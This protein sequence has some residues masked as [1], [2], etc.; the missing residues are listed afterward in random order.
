[1]VKAGKK[2]SAARARA[3][4]QPRL[5][6]PTREE[7]RKA[8]EEW[9]TAPEADAPLSQEAAEP[10][11]EPPADTA[12]IDRAIAHMTGASSPAETAAHPAPVVA[13]AKAELRAT[14]IKARATATA[15]RMRDDDEI[16]EGVFR[17]PFAEELARRIGEP[18]KWNYI[19]NKMAEWEIWPTAK[20]RPSKGHA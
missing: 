12:R 20:I 19:R 3:K 16:P 9:R 17:K 4:R 11:I 2:R 7:W 18:E 14:T 6:A 15:Q 13:T 5:K 1:M 10:A 8:F